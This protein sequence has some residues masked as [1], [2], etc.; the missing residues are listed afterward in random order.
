MFDEGGIGFNKT[1]KDRSYRSYF[2]KATYN[3]CNYCGRVGH[4]SPN[5]TIR[6]NM[7]GN[8]KKR[9]VGVPKSQ[10]HLVKPNL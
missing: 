6:K 2:V 5:S 7:N 4:I 10:V 3:T 9:Y 8:A 1:N